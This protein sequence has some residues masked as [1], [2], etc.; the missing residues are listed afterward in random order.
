M[1][2]LTQSHI[3]SIQKLNNIVISRLSHPRPSVI[4][5][6]WR[7]DTSQD[8]KY[9]A[10]NYNNLITAL[11]SDKTLLRLGLHILS[12]EYLED[13]APHFTKVTKHDNTGFDC[14]VVSDE[15]GEENGKETVTNSE[16]EVSKKRA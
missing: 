11:I 2:P 16:E 12:T 13:G 10:K 3:N 1:A 7:H 5:N 6:K 9:L 4:N 8:W 14:K 15:D